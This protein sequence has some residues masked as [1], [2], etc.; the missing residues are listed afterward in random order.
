MLKLPNCDFCK[1][2][3]D[4]EE[5]EC[6]LAYP[7]GIPLEAMIKAEE[8]VSCMNGYSFEEKETGASYEEPKEGGLFSKLL[9]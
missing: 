4:D 9:K 2:R 3:V 5:K 7:K 8:G 1:H 6:C